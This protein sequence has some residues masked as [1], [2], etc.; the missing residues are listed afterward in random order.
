MFSPRVAR[1]GGDGGE[2]VHM[3]FVATDWKVL[4]F[5]L[6]HP[7]CGQRHNGEQIPKGKMKNCPRTEG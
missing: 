6:M 1:L 5:S 7:L 2:G 4:H 3:D